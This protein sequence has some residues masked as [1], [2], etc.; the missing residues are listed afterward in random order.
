M[1]AGAAIAGGDQDGYRQFVDPNRK[2][3]NNKRLIVLHAWLV[4]L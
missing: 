2:W 1:G 4:L 3:F